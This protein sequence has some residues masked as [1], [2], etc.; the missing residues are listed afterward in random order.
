MR[1]PSKE[2][3]EVVALYGDLFDF[4]A[5][6]VDTGAYH[7]DYHYATYDNSYVAAR[8]SCRSPQKVY[9]GDGG[10]TKLGQIHQEV[11]IHDP[12]EYRYVGL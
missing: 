2:G 9:P 4:D 12:H 1:Y 5:G 10:V 8:S 6:A 11:G 7:E 3:G